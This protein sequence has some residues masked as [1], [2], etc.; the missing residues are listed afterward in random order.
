MAKSFRGCVS[1]VY[2]TGKRKVVIID[3]PGKPGEQDNTYAH[4]QGSN[5]QIVWENMVN[6]VILK[7]RQGGINRIA[8]NPG[9]ADRV[10][11][12]LPEQNKVGNH[13]QSVAECLPKGKIFK[14]RK[15]VYLPV[16]QKQVQ[17]AYKNNAVIENLCYDVSY[18]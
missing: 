4:N 14:V 9:K 1:S 2:P 3:F 7:K 16:L 11:G 5:K 18:G 10:D 8:R 17:N 12:K 13:K 6:Y 15:R